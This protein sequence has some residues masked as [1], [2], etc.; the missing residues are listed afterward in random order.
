EFHVG[1]TVLLVGRYDFTV[2]PNVVSLWIN[3][4]SGVFGA[5]NAPA[6]GFISATNGTDGFTIDR[7]NFRQNTASSVPA[8]MQ[9]D[10][11]RVGTQWADAAP[12]P[13]ASSTIL[14]NIEYLGNGDFQFT[15]ASNVPHNSQTYASSNLVQCM[16]IGVAT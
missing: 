13:T 3:P 2:S 6:T 4:S 8:A 5:S 15:Y 14:T 12:A 9:W 1:D 10:E 7:F 11:L 16:P